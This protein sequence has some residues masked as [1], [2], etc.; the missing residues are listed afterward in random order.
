MTTRR[1]YPKTSEN[2]GS[3][4][5][6]PRMFRIQI[7]VQENNYAP[8]IRSFFPSKIRF[9]GE[10]III[11][12]FYVHFTRWFEFTYFTFSK[13]AWDDLQESILHI[14]CWK[15]VR[16]SPSPNTHIRFLFYLNLS[17]KNFNESQLTW[18][19]W[20]RSNRAGNCLYVLVQQSCPLRF[21]PSWSWYK[22]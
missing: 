2:L 8:Y 11:L 16:I 20:H 4:P 7:E 21:S 6:L 13:Q 17:I 1:P 12:L 14:S 3:R 10:N 22:N 9:L 19:S 15:S 5:K 18:T